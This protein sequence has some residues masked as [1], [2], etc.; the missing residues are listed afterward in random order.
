MVGGIVIS[1]FLDELFLAPGAGNGDFALATGDA[2]HLAALGA[3]EIAVFPVLQAVEKLQEFPVFLIALVGVP[4]HGAPNRPDHQA[5]AQGPEDQVEGRGRNPHR[6]QTCHQSCAQDHHI[7][8]VRA[9]PACHEIT[10]SCGHFCGKLPKPTAKSIHRKITFAK[11]NA[12]L[13]Y[14]A[15]NAECNRLGAKLTDCLRID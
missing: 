8:P 11:R 6:Q 10:Q 9:V 15:K 7:Q 4:G 3:V 14:I 12:F 13:Y 2:H 5:V 1:G